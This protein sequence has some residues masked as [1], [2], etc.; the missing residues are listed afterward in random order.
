MSL[1]K[2]RKRILDLERDLLLTGEDSRAINT[3]QSHE[4]SDL[5]SY[6]DF[7][8]QLWGSQ[9]KKIERRFYPDRFRL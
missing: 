1:R 4:P 6:L 7:L 9:R 5:E 2:E 3:P 8:D